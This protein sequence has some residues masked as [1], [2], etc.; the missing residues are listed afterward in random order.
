MARPLKELHVKA[1]H[2]M[3]LEQLQ[4]IAIR[5]LSQHLTDDQL[6]AECGEYLLPVQILR[7]PDGLLALL[8]P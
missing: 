6:H 7:E 2:C 4:D 5:R 1:L 3:S 8:K